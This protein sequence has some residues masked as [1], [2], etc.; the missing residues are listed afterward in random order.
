MLREAE[1]SHSC[2]HG[3]TVLHPFLATLTCINNPSAGRITGYG[4]QAPAGYR[5]FTLTLYNGQCLTGCS[6][7][8]C[9]A[10]HSTWH[11]YMSQAVRSQLAVPS[12]P[13]AGIVKTLCLPNNF[14]TSSFNI[15]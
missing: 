4:P 6:V 9:S 15:G 14:I 8:M 2:W 10:E 3:R 13:H 11:V 5:T 1:R 12:C 7:G